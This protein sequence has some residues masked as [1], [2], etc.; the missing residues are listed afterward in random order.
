MICE[1]PAG[2]R[3]IA[4]EEVFCVSENPYSCAALCG[5]LK[6]AKKIEG[7]QTFF[8]FL[9]SLLALISVT[10]RV[11]VAPLAASQTIQQVC[12][13]AALA[14]FVV[15]LINVV[16]L[17]KMRKNGYRGYKEH[18]KMCRDYLD[19]T[20]LAKIMSKVKKESAPIRYYITFE[21]PAGI[22]KT[23][24]VNAKTY[25]SAPTEGDAGEL[26]YRENGG[27]LCFVGF[28]RLGDTLSQL[29]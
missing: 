5:S 22:R 14:F 10:L 27:Y 26:T 29:R 2:W 19:V 7:R 6:V 13:V 12:S 16:R 11:W 18:E 15:Y 9:V 3:G 28:V 20:V 21:L 8:V 4:Y 23:F 17:R 25:Y 1:F 24:I